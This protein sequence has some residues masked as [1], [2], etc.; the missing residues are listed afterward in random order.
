[1]GDLNNTNNDLNNENGTP[2]T[3]GPKINTMGIG[4]IIGIVVFVGAI[5]ITVKMGIDAYNKFEEM[6]KDFENIFNE[7]IGQILPEENFG[8]ETVDDENEDGE[9]NIIDPYAKHKNVKFAGTSDTVKNITLYIENGK[10]YSKDL[11]NGKKVEWK[12]EGTPK[13]ILFNPPAVSAIVV[14]EEGKVYDISYDVYEEIAELSKYKIVDI[15]RIDNYTFQNIYYLTSEGN[16]IDVYGVS[17]DKYSFVNSIGHG[18]MWQIPVDKNNYGYHYNYDTDEY[19]VITDKAKAKVSFSKI[20]VFEEYVLIESAYGKLFKYNGTNN[21]AMLQTNSMISRIERKV[22]GDNTNIVVTFVDL[23]TMEFKGIMSAY[24]V[25]KDK[26]IDIEKLAKYVEKPKVEIIE[27]PRDVIIDPVKELEKISEQLQQQLL[28]VYDGKTMTGAEALAAFQQYQNSDISIVVVTNEKG[29]AYTGKYKLE[30][31]SLKSNKLQDAENITEHKPYVGGVYYLGDVINFDANT[32]RT[33]F[34]D[35]WN[36][37]G[38]NAG[39]TYY[40]SLIK[41]AKDNVCGILFLEK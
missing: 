39:Q 30:E 10:V 28:R 2:I 6:S 1:M 26:D 12:V 23:S 24:D 11:E 31:K 34:E 33:S 3:G 35:L 15:A 41:D 16:L 29:A 13:K 19:E 37:F 40:T 7:N 25:K 5:F 8:D 14:T 27:P 18:K 4:V 9:E 20:Y 36:V 32:K 38:I 17:Y 21:T 22:D